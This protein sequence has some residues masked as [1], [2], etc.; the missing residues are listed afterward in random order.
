MNAIRLAQNIVDTVPDPLLILDDALRVRAANR[1]FYLTFN[2]SL[3][4]TE[5]RLVYELGDGQWNIPLLRKL[6][7]EIIPTDST[8]NDYE[9]DHDFPIIGRKIMLLNG[10]KLRSGNHSNLLLLMLEDVTERHRVHDQMSDVLWNCKRRFE[11]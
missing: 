1:A 5:G 7:E 6:L 8:F 4:E 10:R 11:N 9:I 2:V 3:N